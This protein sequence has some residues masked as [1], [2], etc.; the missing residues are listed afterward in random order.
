MKATRQVDAVEMIAS[1][2]ITV[3]HAYALL[4]AAPTEQR[5]YVK[6]AEWEKKTVPIKQIKKLEK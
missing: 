3:A 1:N 4:K 6:P 5:T 2:T